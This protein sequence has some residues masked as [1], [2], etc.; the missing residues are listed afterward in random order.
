MKTKWF[1]RNIDLNLNKKFVLAFVWLLCLLVFAFFFLIHFMRRC[2]WAKSRSSRAAAAAAIKV[3]TANQPTNQPVIHP[4]SPTMIVT[5][6][7][8]CGQ[9]NAR[10][11]TRMN[12]RT[13]EWINKN[14]YNTL[15]KK[16]FVLQSEYT[17]PKA[18][19]HFHLLCI[20]Q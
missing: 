9:T 8:G 18:E 20:I 16:H 12:E 19:L 17:N 5:V 4:Q 2:C 6:V 10:T 13:S 14:T 1:S 3:M 11:H 7:V 15:I